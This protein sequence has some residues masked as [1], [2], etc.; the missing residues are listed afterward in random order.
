MTLE[1]L[2]WDRIG[3]IPCANCGATDEPCTQECAGQ[4]P[5]SANRNQK[6]VQ[7][8]EV[9]TEGASILSA[10]SNS[11][12]GDVQAPSVSASEFETDIEF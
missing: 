7:L 11:L 5:R 3:S 2:E 6:R 4:D 10:S 12:P 9:L 1:E 8:A